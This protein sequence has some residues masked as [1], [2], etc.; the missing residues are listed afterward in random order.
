MS[1]RTRPGHDEQCEW[2]S[3]HKVDLG[4][5][6]IRLLPARE[7]CKCAVRAYQRDPLPEAMREP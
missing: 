6:G 1:E 7:D 3:S 5:L 2:G 4:G